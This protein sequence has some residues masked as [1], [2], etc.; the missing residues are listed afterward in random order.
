LEYR[1]DRLLPDKLAQAYQLLTSGGQLAESEKEVWN[2][3][4]PLRR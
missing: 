3:Q 2:R 4:N 1:F